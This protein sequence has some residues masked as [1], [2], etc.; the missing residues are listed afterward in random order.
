MALADMYAALISQRVY[1]P[2]FEHE[3]AVEIIREKRENHLDPV[4]VDTFTTLRKEFHTIAQP[5]Q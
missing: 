2:A 1:K 3:K 4:V 5:F